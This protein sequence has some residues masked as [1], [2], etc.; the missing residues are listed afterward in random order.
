MQPYFNTVVPSF[1]T[2]KE[3]AT[4]VQYNTALFPNRKKSLSVRQSSE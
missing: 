1:F 3:A 4:E 2:T